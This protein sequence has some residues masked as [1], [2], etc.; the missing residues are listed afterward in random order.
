[1]E[2]N[3]KIIIIALVIVLILVALGVVYVFLRG[4]TEKKET[5]EE[6]DKKLEI[7]FSECSVETS[8]RGS[9]KLSDS[10]SSKINADISLVYSGDA[11]YIN[12]VIENKGNVPAKLTDFKVYNRATSTI[13]DDEDIEVLVPDIYTMEKSELQPGESVEVVFTVKYKNNSDK[14]NADAEF[15]VQVEYEEVSE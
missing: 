13:F 11:C 12:T 9:V 6:V 5:E 15:D 10:D 14:E 3:T 7:V 1:M 4:N 8:D 2:K